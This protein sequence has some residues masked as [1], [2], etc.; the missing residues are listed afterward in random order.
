MEDSPLRSQFRP[1]NP[2]LPKIR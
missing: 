2:L 1:Q